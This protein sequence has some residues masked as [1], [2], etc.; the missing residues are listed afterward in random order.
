MPRPR[1][2]PPAATVVQ[3]VRLT[4]ETFELVRA[5]ARENDRAI[6]AEIRH[7]VRQVVEAES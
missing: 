7:I 3:T 1:L 2:A 5:R 6:G 4:P